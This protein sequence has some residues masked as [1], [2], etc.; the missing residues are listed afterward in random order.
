MHTC[1][2]HDVCIND[3]LQKA[4]MICRNQ[5]VRLTDLRRKVLEMIW[6]GHGFAKA[7][8]ILDKLKSKD[9]S[10]KPP[11]VYRS[12]DFLLKNGLIHKL[13]T[14]NAY[15]GCSHP[16][17]HDECYFIICS[18]CGEVKECCNSMLSRAIIRTASKN[19]FHF[20]RITLEIEG[21]CRECMRQK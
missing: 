9:A 18:K 16:L 12:L 13:N 17:K 4:D 20:K 21:E 19:K 6:V 14:L 1:N 2:H 3:A 8:D 11:T 15:V 7:Y 10:A 5:G